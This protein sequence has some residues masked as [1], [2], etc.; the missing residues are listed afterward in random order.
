MPA[1]HENN[2]RGFWE[3]CEL[4][5]VHE[6][7]LQAIGSS[8]DDV[9][10]L[11]ECWIESERTIGYCAALT[12]FLRNN[13]ESA[14]LFVIKDP[15]VSKLL[16]LWLSVLEEFGAEPKVIIPIRN[17]LEVARSLAAREGFP[18]QKSCLLWLRYTLDSE[19]QSRGVSRSFV[20]Y[21]DLISDW[22]QAASRISKD[23]G[24]SWPADFQDVASDIEMFLDEGL[25]HQRASLDDLRARSDIVD[26]VSRAYEATLILCDKNTSPAA[27]QTIDTIHAEFN[28][29]ALAFK[30]VVTDVLSRAR[31]ADA[32]LREQLRLWRDQVQVVREEQQ[33]WR[34]QVQEMR[35]QVQELRDEQQLWR[36][37]V[38]AL[39]DERSRRRSVFATLNRA[40]G[41]IAGGCG[42]QARG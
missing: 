16:P 35:D 37:R 1:G 38:Q 13:F 36:D 14:P 19:V 24:L 10:A 40:V 30:P 34:D 21:E 42:R 5:R 9:S 25:R 3:S 27:Q 12:T 32:E 7:L 17:P 4:Y 8:W 15:R 31:Q 2:E 22:R 20:R 11:P 33:L 28:K 39:R 41:R 23:L 29:A 26:W 18:L 6:Q